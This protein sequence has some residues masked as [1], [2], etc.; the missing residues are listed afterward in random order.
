MLN[1][2]QCVSPRP[3]VPTVLLLQLISCALFIPVSSQSD[4]PTA[5]PTPLPDVICSPIVSIL[6]SSRSYIMFRQDSPI[7]TADWGA[8]LA[9]GL[10]G[11]SG[12]FVFL[13]ATTES[14]LN[15]FG[16]AVGLTSPQCILGCGGCLLASLTTDCAANVAALLAIAPA[17][18]NPPTTAPTPVA[19]VAPTASSPTSPTA[20]PTAPPTRL[21]TGTTTC[22]GALAFRPADSSASPQNLG[23]GFGSGTQVILPQF[24]FLFSFTFV[25]TVP[26]TLNFCSTGV[27]MWIHAH[28]VTSTSSIGGG[29]IYSCDDCDPCGDLE[30]SANFTV[31]SVNG[32]FGGE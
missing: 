26:A 14:E 29:R 23:P 19:S 2:H 6:G 27:N 3:R 15:S 7:G 13:R 22:F 10:C 24:G 1:H 4:A 31:H 21:V 8:T 25:H 32:Y 18:T 9:L 28:D 17:A 20:A 12:G 5:S 11:G 30:P 16:S